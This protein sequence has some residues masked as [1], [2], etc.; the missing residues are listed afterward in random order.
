MSVN[1]DAEYVPS[2]RPHPRV[3]PEAL[4]YA[5]RNRGG[6]ERWF[7]YSDN[8]NNYNSPR[9]GARVRSEE[10]KQIAET[11]KGSMTDIIGG[12]PDPVP[13]RQLHPRGVTSDAAEIADNNKGGEMKN[14]IDNYGSL[15]VEEQPAPKVKGSEAEEY[16]ERNRGTVNNLISNTNAAPL[17][18]PPV[19]L[20][21]AGS[22]VAAKHTGEGM[23]PLLRMEGEK[24]PKEPKI[25]KLHQESEGGWDEIPPHHRT[26]P[27]AETI[28][29]KNSADSMGAILAMNSSPQNVKKNKVLKHMELTED[30]RP[31]SSPARTRPE[32][33]QYYQKNQTTEMSAIMHGESQQSTHRVTRHQRM[34]QKSEDW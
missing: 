23:G 4:S 7:D 27:E 20:D 30:P 19:K 18:P 16:A 11:N 15:A 6:M 1:G 9:P 22:E 3:K 17:T 5:E 31:R 25:G 12:Y 29:S 8:I 34:M 13:E 21:Q 24:S 26:R 2:P 14:L 10:A 32:A 33:M 28:A